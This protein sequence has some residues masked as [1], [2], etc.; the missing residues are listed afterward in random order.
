MGGCGRVACYAAGGGIGGAIAAFVVVFY[1]WVAGAILIDEADD[2]SRDDTKFNIGFIL[3]M[4]SAG[5]AGVGCIIG[6]CQG[7]AMGLSEVDA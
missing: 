2:K 4:V 7:T 3:M 1:L 5:F 6:A